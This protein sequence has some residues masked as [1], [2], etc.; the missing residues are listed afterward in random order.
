[1]CTVFS[2][3][4][5]WEELEGDISLELKEGF[6]EWSPLPCT[7]YDSVMLYIHNIKMYVINCKDEKPD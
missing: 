5:G 2:L 6:L 7:K 4:V 1:M 3:V